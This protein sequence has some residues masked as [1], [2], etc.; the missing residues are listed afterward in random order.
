MTVTTL[1]GQ[2]KVSVH[3]YLEKGDVENILKI[4]FQTSTL[5]ENPLISAIN[6]PISYSRK[7]VRDVQKPLI[8]Q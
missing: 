6:N 1:R 3:R 8:S 7:P 2:N 5:I 4:I